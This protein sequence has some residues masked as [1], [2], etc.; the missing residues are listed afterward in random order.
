MTKGYTGPDY[1]RAALNASFCKPS[2]LRAFR[3]QSMHGYAM[4]CCLADR[5]RNFCVP[6]QGT[7]YPTLW[8]F[9]HCGGA[10]RRTEV[11]SGRHRNVYTIT[12]KGRKAFQAGATVWRHRLHQVQGLLQKSPVSS[13][14]T[15]M[16]P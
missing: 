12:A 10:R 13:D 7:V 16:I 14:E 9:E 5:K 1:W 11:F 6:T 8:E 4:I 15:R 2:I 3:D